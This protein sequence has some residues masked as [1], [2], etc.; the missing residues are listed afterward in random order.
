PSSNANI[1]RRVAGRGRR[2]GVCSPRRQRVRLRPAFA[3]WDRRV[4][5]ELEERRWRRRAKQREACTTCE[6]RD[7]AA[8]DFAEGEFNHREHRGS[9]RKRAQK[10]RGS[11]EKLPARSLAFNSR[12]TTTPHAGFDLRTNTA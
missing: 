9:Q 7:S 1:V 5:S 8:F 4:R 11:Q 10:M 6:A 2:D 3:G 12:N